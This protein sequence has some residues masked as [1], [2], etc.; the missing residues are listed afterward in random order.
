MLSCEVCGREFLKINKLNRHRLS[1]SDSRPFVCPFPDCGKSYAR[2]D[3]LNRHSASHATK[4]VID[5]RVILYILLLYLLH[6]YIYTLL[7][8]Y[9]QAQF[10]CTVSGCTSHFVTP[11]KLARHNATVHKLFINISTNF[12]AA[13]EYSGVDSPLRVSLSADHCVIPLPDNPTCFTG[14]LE[15]AFSSAIDTQSTHRTLNSISSAARAHNLAVAALVTVS[16]QSLPVSINSDKGALKDPLQLNGVSLAHIQ[17]SFL[18]TTYNSASRH[19]ASSCFVCPHCPER[20]SFR[21]AH[22]LRHHLVKCHLA[23]PLFICTSPRYWFIE[24]SRLI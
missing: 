2:N 18:S 22:K 11:D 7:F 13:P 14:G 3:H 6:I 20:T 21:K 15:A 8:C 12:D 1:H 16:P 9:F 17:N 19:T 24:G 5:W 23:G 10:A 4:Q